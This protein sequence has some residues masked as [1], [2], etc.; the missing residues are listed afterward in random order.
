MIE[1]P[2]WNMAIVAFI[3][4]FGY[5]ATWIHP[6]KY[7]NRATRAAYFSLTLAWAGVVVAYALDTQMEVKRAIFLVLTIAYIINTP[8]WIV[9]AGRVRHWLTP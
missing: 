2:A 1:I 5:L 6:E 9:Q 7:A 8:F 3:A 4:M